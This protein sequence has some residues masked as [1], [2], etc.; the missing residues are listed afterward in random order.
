MKII[1]SSL[2]SLL[3]T[4]LLLGIALRQEPESPFVAPPPAP[5]REA[6]SLE[7]CQG[8]VFDALP[9]LPLE[10]L[11]YHEETE[12]NTLY[13]LW[14]FE[15]IAGRLDRRQIDQRGGP[16]FDL[17][18]VYTAPGEFLWAAAGVTI[19]PYY[20]VHDSASLSE[21]KKQGHG[22]EPYY[23]SYI[24]GLDSAQEVREAL[25]T[26][27]AYRVALSLNGSHVS[28]AGVDWRA[29]LPAES[30]ACLL[31]AFIDRLL[32]SG[33]GTLVETGHGS[34]S[35]LYGF[36]TFQ[37]ILRERLDLCAVQE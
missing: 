4:F 5:N 28:R 34:R 10:G 27:G 32:L 14:H 9:D 1:F 13:G 8:K 20:F 17:V 21:Y 7:A 24:N 33:N 6:L 30:D 2:F 37:L 23:L 11:T 36:I 26:P 25:G 35:S 12:E 15:G 19:P 16:V 18:Q 22:D 3:S 29:C 31:G